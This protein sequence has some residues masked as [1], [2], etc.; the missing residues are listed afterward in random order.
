MTHVFADWEH[1]GPHAVARI[2]TSSWMVAFAASRRFTMRICR[3]GRDHV[4][5]LSAACLTVDE[6]SNTDDNIEYT[7]V[8]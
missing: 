3:F 6:L 4:C 8:I 5:S 2:L 7:H 1:N